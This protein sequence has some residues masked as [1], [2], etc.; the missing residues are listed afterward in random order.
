MTLIMVLIN[1]LSFVALNKYIH[2]S[3]T[4]SKKAFYAQRSLQVLTNNISHSLK[5]ALCMKFRAV[6]LVSKK[7]TRW[8]RGH[9]FTDWSWHVHF[10]LTYELTLILITFIYLY[11]IMPW[12]H[13]SIEKNIKTSKKI[14]SSSYH[15]LNY[16][17]Q[18]LKLF[19]HTDL[20]ILL[21][22]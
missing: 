19:T 12:K 7:C 15:L 11:T 3:I 20:K 8:N 9:L 16:L 10:I 21:I 6:L 17:F 22:W 18:V 1:T 4:S 2:F 13:S 5:T 14:F